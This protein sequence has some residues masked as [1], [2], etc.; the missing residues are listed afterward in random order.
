VIDDYLVLKKLPDWQAYLEMVVSLRP[1]ASLHQVR[2]LNDQLRFNDSFYIAIT[3]RSGV[4][5]GVSSETAQVLQLSDRGRRL[6]DILEEAG[7][8]HKIIAEQIVRELSALWS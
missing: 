4:E 8:A 7:L 2:R 5:Y 3:Q 1:Y 6:R